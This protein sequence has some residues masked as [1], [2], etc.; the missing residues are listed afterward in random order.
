MVAPRT[1]AERAA[2]A[3][4]TIQANFHKIPPGG[5]LRP[6]QTGENMEGRRLFSITVGAI[7]FK[8]PLVNPQDGTLVKSNSS[9]GNTIWATMD[10]EELDKWPLLSLGIVEVLEE[11]ANQLSQR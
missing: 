5:C 1:L 10:L 7:V 11:S 3:L 4:R 9:G 8:S 6:I 2:T